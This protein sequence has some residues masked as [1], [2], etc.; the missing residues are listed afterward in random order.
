VTRLLDLGAEPFLVAATLEAVL[1]QRLVRRI[2]PHCRET[3]QTSPALLMQLDLTADKIGGRPIFAGRGCGHCAQTGYLGRTGIFEWLAMTE[4]MREL[5][6]DQAPALALRQLAREQGRRTLRDD[7][8][9][10]VFAGATT[11][12]EIARFT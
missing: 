2:C 10:S 5:V 7:G 9:R 11:L 4:A 6:A 3:C 1:A 12:E 8:L